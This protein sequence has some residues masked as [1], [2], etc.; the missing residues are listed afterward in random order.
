MRARVAAGFCWFWVV[1]DSVFSVFTLGELK[2]CG[3]VIVPVS[4]SLP[5][6]LSTSWDDLEH[7]ITCLE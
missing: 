4:Y 1:L 7:S 2:R 6:K 3:L 5:D